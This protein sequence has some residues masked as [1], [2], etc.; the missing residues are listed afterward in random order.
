MP[1]KPRTPED[2]RTDPRVG[3]TWTNTDGVVYTVVNVDTHEVSLNRLGGTCCFR[4]FIWALP[5][6]TFAPGPYVPP[7]TETTARLARALVDVV[8]NR[9]DC[10]P[11]TF[12]PALCGALDLDPDV[13]SWDD[14]AAALRALGGAL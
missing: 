3:D 8:V 5:G 2:V 11:P 12:G 7:S 13:A 6:G 14:V 9:T 1:P 4:R 10:L